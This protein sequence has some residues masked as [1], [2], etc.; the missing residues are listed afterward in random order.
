MARMPQKHLP[1]AVQLAE[2]CLL[3]RRALVAAGLTPTSA[4][5]SSARAPG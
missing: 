4:I 1:A 3:T 2:D 5:G